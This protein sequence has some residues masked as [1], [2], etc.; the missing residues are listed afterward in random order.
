MAEP[1]TAQITIDLKANSVEHAKE[2]W[3]AAVNLVET[4]AG[5]GSGVLP[6]KG[7]FSFRVVETGN[8]NAGTLQAEINEILNQA[9]NSEPK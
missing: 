2:L 3:L 4:S 9:L 7:E 6:G 5:G 1:Y 8:P